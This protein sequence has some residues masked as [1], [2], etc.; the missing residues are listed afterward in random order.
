MKVFNTLAQ[1]QLAS[2]LTGT[3]VRVLDPALIDGVVVDA[4]GD[5]LSEGFP[6]PSGNV[7]VP[8]MDDQEALTGRKSTV[9]VVGATIAPFSKDATGVWQV[10]LAGKTS[11]FFHLGQLWWPDDEATES[12]TV[13]S[14]GTPVG[15]RLDVQVR[16][17][18][19]ALTYRPYSRFAGLSQDVPEQ[20]L[21]VLQPVQL[22]DGT[23]TT[24]DAPHAD[25]SPATSFL[26]TVDGVVQIPVDSYTT[27]PGQISFTEAPPAGA[28][29]SVTFYRPVSP[30]ELPGTDVSEALAVAAGSIAPRTMENWTYD[31][32]QKAG[33]TTEEVTWYVSPTGSDTAGDGSQANPFKTVQMAWNSIPEIIYHPQT[34]QLADGLYNESVEP[35]SSQARAAILYGYGKVTAYRSS[36]NGDE[37]DGA[38]TIR[39]NLTNPENVI[40]ETTS[41][42]KYGVYIQKGNI[43]INGITIQSNGVNKSS[44]L[45]V[46]HRTDTYVHV[47]K[48]IIDGR[49]FATYGA[50]TESN[51]QLEIT[52]D[53]KIRNCD[54]NIVTLTDGDVITISN[55][56][57]RGAL[58]R[59]VQCLYGLIQMVQ[60]DATQLNHVFSSGAGS[61]G[62]FVGAGGTVRC[63]GLSSTV[64]S[65]I[66]DGIEVSSGG[67]MTM[68]WFDIDLEPAEVNEGSTLYMNNS[69]FSRI[70]YLRG[71]STLRVTNCQATT[72]DTEPVRLYDTST[73]QY[74]GGTNTIRGSGGIPPVFHDSTLSLTSNDQVVSLTQGIDRYRLTGGS[75][76]KTGCEIDVDGVEYG[77]IVHLIGYSWQVSLPDTPTQDFGSTGLTVGN[78][79]GAHSSATLY[80][81]LGVWRI[82]GVGKI[83]D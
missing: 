27:A 30:G 46:A 1:L 57:L 80:N 21:P 3:P 20:Q 13:V 2:I 58:I 69:T 50:Y 44:G 47:F 15:D 23:K 37:L 40:I 19:G 29:V 4:T 71:G 12:F 51:G 31:I 32:T 73:I 10:D 22:G 67:T 83:V 28:Q 33:R 76:A 59:N 17:G 60:T 78:Q 63:A 24:F 35:A 43:G 62:V 36:S 72:A 5:F 52:K 82:L 41:D 66:N 26:V 9:G 55:S 39:G 16:D 38:I 68:T 74:D 77:R 11:T 45:L 64:R 56:T 81:D 6:L 48:T 79:A 25:S 61:L 8:K 18:S 65:Q 49:G 54:Y 53:S 34:I 70:I 42:Y 75:S 7:F 14:I